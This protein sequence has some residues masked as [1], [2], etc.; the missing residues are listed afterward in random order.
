MSDFF[1]LWKYFNND[2]FYKCI[3]FMNTKDKMYF[4]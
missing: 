4:K 2:L 1:N 3:I